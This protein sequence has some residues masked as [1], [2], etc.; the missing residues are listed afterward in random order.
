MT[1]HPLRVPTTLDCQPAAQ[2]LG[3]G[4]TVSVIVG[5]G[6]TPALAAHP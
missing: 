1:P 3:G 6:P 4:V 2:R 5:T